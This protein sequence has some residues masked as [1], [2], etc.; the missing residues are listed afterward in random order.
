MRDELSM[1]TQNFLSYHTRLRERMRQTHRLPLSPVNRQNLPATEKESENTVRKGIPDSMQVNQM[2][3]YYSRPRELLHTQEPSLQ[4]RLQHQESPPLQRASSSHRDLRSQ[5]PRQHLQE[6]RN[7]RNAHCES[8]LFRSKTVQ[9]LNRESS[10][11]QNWRREQRFD[12]QAHCNQYQRPRGASIA[13]LEN[14]AHKHSDIRLCKMSGPVSILFV[15]SFNGSKS[16]PQ[17]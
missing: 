15:D 13:S 3:L 9:P 14:I 5:N 17:W 16:G 10:S 11:S 7:A 6:G 12:Q 1:H 8:N 4:E 2:P